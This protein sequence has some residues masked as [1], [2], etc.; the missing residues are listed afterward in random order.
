MSSTDRKP[1]AMVSLTACVQT[2]SSWNA[3]QVLSNKG[4]C[5]SRHGN[6]PAD[7]LLRFQGMASAPP[8]PPSRRPPSRRRAVSTV[9]WGW[10]SSSRRRLYVSSSSAS[11]SVSC[12]L[13]GAVDC[14]FVWGAG[15]SEELL[16]PAAQN[17]AG[18]NDE[19]NVLISMLIVKLASVMCAVQW[20]IYNLSEI[21]L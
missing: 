10:S 6:P 15:N 19:L 17:K 11:S 3:G 16:L 13:T 21:D 8:C 12:W 2:M 4:P 14:L 20:S 9:S 7:F 5:S 1:A 18:I